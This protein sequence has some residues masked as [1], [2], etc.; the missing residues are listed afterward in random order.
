MVHQLVDDGSEY[1]G[2]VHGGR[3][4][5][6]LVDLIDSVF[7]LREC[8]DRTLG[9]GRKCLYADMGRCLAPCEG[10]DGR[11][12]LE[13]ES[14]RQFLLGRDESIPRI[15]EDRMRDAASR[16]DFEEAREYRDWLAMLERLLAQQREVAAPVLEHN[17]VIL[18]PAV[19]QD[20]LQLFFVRFGRYVYNMMFPRDPN[21]DDRARLC[22]SVETFFNPSQLR[23]ARYHKREV[24]EIN[25]LLNWMYSH[26]DTAETVAWDGHQSPQEFAGAVIKHIHERMPAPAPLLKRA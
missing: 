13:V 19:D 7:G 8:D 18:Q 12:A 26:R 21:A 15:L 14:V 4:A 20:A 6:F 17:A 16:L 3:N 1:F 11:Y 10:D 9:A 24:D 2:P 25:I 5:A 22:H 23:P